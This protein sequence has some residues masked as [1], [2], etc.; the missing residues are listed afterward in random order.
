MVFTDDIIGTNSGCSLLIQAILG[1]FWPPCSYILQTK[2]TF[3]AL[4]MLRLTVEGLN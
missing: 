1:L 4:Q 3:L 2:V